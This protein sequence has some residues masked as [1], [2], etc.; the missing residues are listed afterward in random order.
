MNNLVQPALS[1]PSCVYE[2]VLV[3]IKNETAFRDGGDKFEDV[4]FYPVDVPVARLILADLRARGITSE[5]AD[6]FLDRH[7]SSGA[8]E[9]IAE[10]ARRVF[11]GVPA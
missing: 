7:R 9:V 2:R 4:V 8:R 11:A 10:V 5:D 3:W 1:H 6:L